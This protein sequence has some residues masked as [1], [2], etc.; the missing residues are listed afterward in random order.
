MHAGAIT[1]EEG[2]EVTIEMLPGEDAYEASEQN[3]ILSRS[4]GI[5]GGSFAVVTD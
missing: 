5:W 4:Y 3:G 1:V 2:G